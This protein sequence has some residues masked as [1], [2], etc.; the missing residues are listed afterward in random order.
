MD[1][2]DDGID[3]IGLAIG[4]P[5]PYHRFRTDTGVGGLAK[6]KWGGDRLDILAVHSETAGRGQ[7]RDFIAWSK[8]QFKTICIWYIAEPWLEKVL[9][10][11]GFVPETDISEDGEVM[12]GMRWD[13]NGS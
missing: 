11:Y 7:F 2:I 9:D 10:R 3:P 4:V 5:N 12:E 6:W 1:L 13:K 8:T